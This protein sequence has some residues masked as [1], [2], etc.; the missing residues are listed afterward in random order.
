MKPVFGE[1]YEAG[2][3]GFS[4]QP[5]TLV[6]EGI[7][8]VTGDEAQSQVRVSHAFLVEDDTYCIEATG[9]GVVRNHLSHYFGNHYEVYFKRPKSLSPR[10]VELVLDAARP[11]WARATPLPASSAC[12][13]TRCSSWA[14]AGAGWPAAATPSTAAP[15]GSAR[16]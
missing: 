15:P 16:S 12:S 9:Q 4:F 8:I 6:S 11:S 10:R 1:T 7:T 2:L 14:I 5:G 13:P 3:V